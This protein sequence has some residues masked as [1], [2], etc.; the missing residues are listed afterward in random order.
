MGSALQPPE[1]S[2]VTDLLFISSLIFSFTPNPIKQYICVGFCHRLKGAVTA[3]IEN[4]PRL[5]LVVK[6]HP[7]HRPGNPGKSQEGEWPDRNVRIIH[8]TCVEHRL[9]TIL[10]SFE[11]LSFVEGS[12]VHLRLL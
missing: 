5:C 2:H 8:S 10:I 4:E 6:I 3:A 9:W 12:S 11:P 7:S 1:C